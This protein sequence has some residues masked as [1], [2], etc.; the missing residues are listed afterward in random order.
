MLPWLHKNIVL[1]Q[2][3]ALIWSSFDLQEHPPPDKVIKKKIL[4]NKF[5]FADIIS[6]N[7]L[8]DPLAFAR[9]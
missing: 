8:L 5:H 9:H 6:M 2:K 7:Q 1:K 3:I 4:C